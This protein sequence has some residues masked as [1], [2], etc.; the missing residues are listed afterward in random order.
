MS[1]K[2]IIVVFALILIIAIIVGVYITV[3]TDEKQ[4]DNS[5]LKSPPVQDGPGIPPIPPPASQIIDPCAEYTSTSKGISQACYDKIWKDVGCTTTG[6]ADAS[7]SWA[8]DKTYDQL[9]YDSKLWATWTDNTHREGCYG[10]DRTKWPNLGPWKNLNAGNNAYVPIRI[11]PLGVVECMSAN[12]ADCYWK[13]TSAEVDE[14]IANPP[15]ETTQPLV[16]ADYA[17]KNKD[18]WCYKGTKQLQPSSS[19]LPLAHIR[20]YMRNNYLHY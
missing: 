14:L 5:T 8:K 2:V 10:T 6:K 4:S 17:I 9:V 7:T 15:V 19:K 18:H 12:N 20:N 1:K 13:G 11:G 3:M 16:C